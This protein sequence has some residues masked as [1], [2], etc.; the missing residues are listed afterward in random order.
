VHGKV[1]T[2]LTAEDEIYGG[3]VVLLETLKAGTTTFLEAGSYNPQASDRRPEPYRHA[4][5][6]GAPLVRPGNTRAWHAARGYRQPA[7]PKT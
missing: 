5:I 3:L 6:D 4:R 1:A 7:S 2:I